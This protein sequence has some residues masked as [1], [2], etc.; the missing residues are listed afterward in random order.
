M[1]HTLSPRTEPYPAEVT[2]ILD[3]YPKVEGALLQLFRVFAQSPRFLTKCVPNLLDPE[4][5]LSLTERELIILRV[6][7]NLGCEYEWGVHVAVFADAASLSTL[8][9]S[10]I[11]ESSYADDCWTEEQK[12][13]LEAVDQLL[14]S[15][16]LEPGTLKAFRD[17]WTAEQ[18]LEIFA[19]CGT[20][21]TIS[22]VAN[23]AAMPLEEFAARFPDA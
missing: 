18:Q 17:C 16:R 21:T 9:V 1:T 15:G 7:A 8:Q 23:Q 12:L 14:R 5:P 11:R 13:L 22:L 2:A 6:T 10:A 3:N 4:S 19:L 20:Y